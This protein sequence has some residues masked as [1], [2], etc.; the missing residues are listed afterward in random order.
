MVFVRKNNRYYKLLVD[1]IQF[2]KAHGSY[3][4]IITRTEKFS[5]ALNLSQ[6]MRKN[7]ANNLIRVHRSFIINIRSLDSFDHEFIYVDRHQIPISDSFRGEF[8][9]SIHS[10]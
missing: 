3:L 8:L 10:I 1:D 4:E 5:V 6:F 2:I 7:P 9:K